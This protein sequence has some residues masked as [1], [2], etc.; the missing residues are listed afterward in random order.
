LI[1]AAGRSIVTI[2]P[3]VGTLRKV[4]KVGKLLPHINLTSKGKKDG[5]DSNS[6]QLVTAYVT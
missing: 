3:S 2:P 6:S 5:G 4:G 1:I